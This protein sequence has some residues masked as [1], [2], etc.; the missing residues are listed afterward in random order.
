MK[1][2][3]HPKIKELQLRSKPV[4]YYD[5]PGDLLSE[6]QTRAA[7]IKTEK[8]QR[9]AYF[10]IWGQKDDKGT[11]WMKGAFTKSIQERGPKSKA[12][13]KIAVVYYHDLRDP[14]G[15]P[16][17]IVEDDFGAYVVFEWAD[18]DAVPSAKRA[19]SLIEQE[20]M[21]GWSFG[22]DYVWDKMKYDE[23]QETVWIHEADLYE[24]S[25]L[26]FGSNRYTLSLRSKAEFETAKLALDQ[27]TEDALTGLPRIKQ[28][29][30]RQLLT[31]HIS[32]AK[33]EPDT[34]EGIREKTLKKTK[35]MKKASLYSKLSEH[36]NQE[37]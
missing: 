4:N 28:L 19:K 6:L 36:L 21:N 7:S 32:L 9:A 15:K 30:I 27:E 25:P 31:K 2:T 13:Q 10:C 14:I 24:I 1:T 23:V 29:E 12:K 16:I 26:L 20:I 8:N 11:G 3:L 35:P 5:I 37:K 22:F 18:L 17:E 33:L 34:P